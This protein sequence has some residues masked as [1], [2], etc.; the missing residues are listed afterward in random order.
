MA[1]Q[2][3][4]ILLSGSSSNSQRS[5]GVYTSPKNDWSDLLYHRTGTPGHRSLL[6][7]S[8]GYNST[9]GSASP[10]QALPKPSQRRPGSDADKYLTVLLNDI[11]A[12]SG[13]TDDLEE[14]MLDSNDSDQSRQDTCN[15]LSMSQATTTTTSSLDGKGDD[16]LDTDHDLNGLGKAGRLREKNKQAQRRHR[17]KQKVWS[18]HGAS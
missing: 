5:S 11:I 18:H 6:T 9:A 12:A 3:F 8:P 13:Q 14:H 16:G 2:G 7:S 15:T 4:D 10:A 17:Q 1:G